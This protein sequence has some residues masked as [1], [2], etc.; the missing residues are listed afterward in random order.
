M[1]PCSSLIM[2][3]LLFTSLVFQLHQIH[4]SSMVKKNTLFKLFFTL[5]CN[6]TKGNIWLNGFIILPMTTLGNL[7][8]TYL[9]AERRLLNSSTPFNP[10]L[11]PVPRMLLAL[12]H[13]ISNNSY[14]L[15]SCISGYSIVDF[16]PY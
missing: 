13:N 7:K 6:I 3:L 8:A 15:F 1:C 2:T 14:T 16:L 12:F 11:N 5:V 10:R 9:I 4:S